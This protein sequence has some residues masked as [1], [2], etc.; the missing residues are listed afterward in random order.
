MGSDTMKFHLQWSVM[1]VLNY[2]NGMQYTKYNSS[3]GECL[4]RK[5][6]WWNDDFIVS[7]PDPSKGVFKITLEF[8]SDTLLTELQ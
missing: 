2:V 8:N 4:I 7:L 1:E 6:S 3:N 5:K